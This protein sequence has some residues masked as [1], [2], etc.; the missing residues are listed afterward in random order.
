M[1]NEEEPRH[2]CNH[3]SVQIIRKKLNLDKL[4]G[5]LTLIK[6]PE[7]PRLGRNSEAKENLSDSLSQTS[8]KNGEM[9]K[10]SVVSFRNNL[11]STI[12]KDPR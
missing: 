1:D 2:L 5:Y 8:S 6:K 9:D 11:G 12:T 10:T 3:P 7:N 4:C